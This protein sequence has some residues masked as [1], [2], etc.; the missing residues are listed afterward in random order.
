MAPAPSLSDQ[1]E[2]A[3]AE[4][5][6]CRG[7]YPSMVRAGVMAQA[8]MDA[9]LAQQ[10]AIVASLRRLE[11]LQL[12]AD[13]ATIVPVEFIEQLRCPGRQAE[14]QA[15]GVWRPTGLP[16][17]RHSVSGSAIPPAPTSRTRS[18]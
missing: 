8:A 18:A 6:R 17:G 1:I 13:F 3:E 12:L 4:A 11:L 16:A 5:A 14:V 9:E 2:Y 15:S 7:V 10:A